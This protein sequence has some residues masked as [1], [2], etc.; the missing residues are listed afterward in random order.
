MS[1]GRGVKRKRTTIVE[2]D[3]VQMS[4]DHSGTGEVTIQPFE[5]DSKFISIKNTSGDDINIGGWA[6]SNTTEDGQD[7]TYKFHRNITLHADDECKVYSADSDEV[8][9]PGKIIDNSS[10]VLFF[11][12]NFL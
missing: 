11:A 7:A 2:E 5:K 1:S 6:L 8:R 12:I 3:V 4:S 10:N 9:I